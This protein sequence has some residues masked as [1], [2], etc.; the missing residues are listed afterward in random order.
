MAAPFSDDAA[1]LKAVNEGPMTALDALVAQHRKSHVKLIQ[2]MQEAEARHS[3]V[4]IPSADVPFGSTGSPI[5]WKCGLLVS[6]GQ[7]DSFQGTPSI[8]DTT[9]VELAFLSELSARIGSRISTFHFKSTKWL[10]WYP[11]S[12][13]YIYHLSVSTISGIHLTRV[14]SVYRVS[15][16]RLWRSVDSVRHVCFFFWFVG[17]V[18]FFN[19]VSPNVEFL[20][21]FSRVWFGSIPACFACS[22]PSSYRVFP[23]ISASSFSISLSLSVAY[24][25]PFFT[26][27]FKQKWTHVGIYDCSSTKSEYRFEYLSISGRLFFIVSAVGFLFFFFLR[28]ERAQRERGCSHAE[29]PRKNSGRNVQEN[30]NNNRIK[31]K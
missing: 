11:S 16:A 7:V 28:L 6:N 4:R 31:K 3:K 8:V 27:E 23:F 24:S 2:A 14:T 17:S 1:L 29:P 10:E 26:F 25:L 19:W 21:S 15:R 5:I 13:F 20:F 18:A 9:A 12:F 22:A 30:D